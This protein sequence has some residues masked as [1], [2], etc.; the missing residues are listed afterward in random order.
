M[1]LSDGPPELPLLAPSSLRAG[2]FGSAPG[3][4][5]VARAG[6]Q[7]SQYRGGFDAFEEVGKTEMGNGLGKRAGLF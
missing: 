1:D 2:G 3:R 5:W 7:F 6:G 4:G